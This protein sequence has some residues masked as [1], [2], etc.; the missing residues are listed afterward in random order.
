MKKEFCLFCKKELQYRPNSYWGYFCSGNDLNHGFAINDL[1]RDIFF[2]QI[3]NNDAYYEIYNSRFSIKE[4]FY[5]SEKTILLPKMSL[6][7]S[8]DFI[9][10]YDILS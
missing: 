6:E 5:S 2:L 1:N 9:M 10:N 3:N 4:S 7:E 8:F